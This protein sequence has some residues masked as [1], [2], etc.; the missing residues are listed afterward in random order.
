MALVEKAKDLKP[1]ETGE[2]SLSLPEDSGLNLYGLES[3]VAGA[4]RDDLHA[5]LSTIRKF[6]T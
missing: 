6:P 5:S 2:T 3:G 4:E 1:V